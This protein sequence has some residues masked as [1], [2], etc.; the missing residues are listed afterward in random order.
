MVFKMTGRE[1]MDL[2]NEYAGFCL[3]CGEQAC[4]CEPDARQYECESCGKKQVY[5]IQELL[6]MGHI[7]LV[8]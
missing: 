5:G 8:D 1:F 7:D 4:G 2:D 6:L 3:A